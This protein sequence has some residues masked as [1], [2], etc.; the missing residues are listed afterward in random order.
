[1]R[2]GEATKF[3]HSGPWH[4]PGFISILQGEQSHQHWGYLMVTEGQVPVTETQALG[5]LQV[6][7]S[8]DFSFKTN[9]TQTASNLDVEFQ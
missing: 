1:M 2:L 9:Q 8:N 6:M 5:S 3:K 4:W 7:I